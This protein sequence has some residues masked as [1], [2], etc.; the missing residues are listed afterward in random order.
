[1]SVSEGHGYGMMLV[2]YMAG[3]DSEAQAIFDNLFRFY[4][5]SKCY[6]PLL[7]GVAASDGKW[8]DCAWT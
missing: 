3:Y 8:N 2:A 6:Y 1:M 7:N 5:F 4:K